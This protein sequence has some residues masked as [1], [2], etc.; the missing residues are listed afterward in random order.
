MT[1][2]HTLMPEW[3][4]RDKVIEATTEHVFDREVLLAHIERT[5]A[6]S[7]VPP[8]IEDAEGID[9]VVGLVTLG[10]AP[11]ADS[12][13]VDCETSHTTGHAADRVG[14][15][16]TERSSVS[17]PLT[18]TRPRPE[19]TAVQEES[20]ASPPDAFAEEQ[21][22]RILERTTHSSEVPLLIEDTVILE[23]IAGVL[24]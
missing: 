19:R 7:G 11:S 24:A 8:Q 1:S 23:Q 21:L 12:S 3:R 9:A 2:T 22:V 5:R 10:P 15:R 18:N 6:A 14:H 16:E 17:I 4:S 20:C 13:A